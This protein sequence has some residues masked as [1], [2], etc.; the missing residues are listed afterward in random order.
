MPG[1]AVAE[2]MYPP[3]WPAPSAASRRR[4]RLADTRKKRRKPRLGAMPQSKE[5]TVKTARQIM[6]KRLRPSVPG[7]PAADRQNDGVRDQIR[8]QHPG[9]LVVARAQISG[10]VRQGDVGDAGVE[11]LHERSQ[12]HD[13]GNQPGIV[14]GPPNVLVE[15]ER[16]GTHC[17]YTSGTTF[18]PGRSR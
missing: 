4:P 18:M 7:K 16:G 15:C 8:S 14:L 6:K 10:H 12:C 17:R 5:L 2:E 9:A 3:E 13:H 1:R 11:H